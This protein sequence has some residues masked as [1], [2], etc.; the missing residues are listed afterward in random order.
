MGEKYSQEKAEKEA[1]YM[2]SLIKLGEAKNYD[3]AEQYA[4]RVRLKELSRSLGA[5]D[6]CTYKLMK[7]IW[8][9]DNVYSKY[10]KQ[11]IAAAKRLVVKA[12]QDTKTFLEK[13]EEY[14]DLRKKLKL[15]GALKNTDVNE[16][17][18]DETKASNKD[19]ER[20][21]FEKD[22]SDEWKRSQVESNMSTFLNKIE[23]LR[24]KTLNSLS[25]SEVEKL[26]GETKT[27]LE[28]LEE[29]CVLQDTFRI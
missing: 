9:D 5:F 28:D 27:F 11:E 20:L 25:K 17:I 3:A 12:I 2:K 6:A 4:E 16:E 21:T 14:I 26:G 23:G 7:N 8:I 29:Y 18:M 22:S 1:G 13:I 19:K 10:K 15:K 24:D